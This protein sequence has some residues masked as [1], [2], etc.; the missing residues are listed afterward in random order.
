VIVPATTTRGWTFANHD[1]VFG[2]NYTATLTSQR[3]WPLPTPATVVVGPG[4]TTWWT[5]DITAPDTAKVGVNRICLTLTSPAGVVVRQC[6]YNLT[7]TGQAS[8]GGPVAEHGLALAAGRPN[9]APG[10]ATIAFTLPTAG[11]A[12]LVVYDLAGARVRT[13]VDESR[14]AGDASVTWDGADEHG[15][16]VRAGAYFYRLEF[17]GHELSQRI[18]IV[19]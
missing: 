8:V 12:R 17:G 6:C 1:V 7:V 19:R 4:G 14:S 3:N 9:P 16:P 18:V 5:A 10:R 11:H 13:L 15:R 2:G